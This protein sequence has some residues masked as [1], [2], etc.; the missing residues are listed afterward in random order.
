MGSSR[1]RLNAQSLRYIF[2]RI[3]SMLVSLGIV[4]CSS[5]ALD[6]T[7][8][9]ALAQSAPAQSDFTPTAA[10]AQAVPTHPLDALTAEEYV[11]TRSL[12]ADAGYVNGDSRFPLINLREPTKAEVLAWKP[13][14]AIPRS[15]DVVV[16]QG[17]QTYEAVVDLS[18]A[19]VKSWKE[20]EEAQPSLLLEEFIGVTELTIRNAEWRAAVQKRG[21]TDFTQIFCSPLTAGYYGLAEEEGRRILKVPCYDTRGTKN[22]WFGKPIEGVLTVVDLNNMQ[23]LKVIDTGVIPISPDPASYDQASVKKLR[24]ALNPTVISQPAGSNIT[25]EDSFINW[26]KWSFHL[27][28][29]RRL[30]SIISLVNYDDD[31]RSR[32]I[33]YQGALSEIFVPYMDP[34]EPWY[35]RT[36]MD[37]GEYGAG[38]L[39]TPLAPGI[40]CPTTAAMF[41]PVLADDN[42]N[43]FT[44]QN[45][46]CVFERSSGDPIWRHS[47]IL[48][49]TYEGRPQTD[50]VV[51]MMSTIG[52]YDYILDWIFTQS[53][54][55]NVMVG[56]TGIDAVKGVMSQTMSDPTAI[57]DTAYGSLIAPGITAPNHDHFFSFRLDL[58]I[59]GQANRFVKDVF[60][61]E[62]L[63]D[64][65]PRRSL[66]KTKSVTVPTDSEAKLTVSNGHPSR[67]RMVSSDVKNHV[68]NA[69][70]YQISPMGSQ[71]NLLLPDDYPSRRAAFANYNLWITPY[72]PNEIYAAGKYPN[73]SKG[74]DGLPEWTSHSR[75]LLDTDLVAWNTVGFHHTPVSEDWPI[76]S[77]TWHGFTLKPVNFF[78]RNPALDIPNSAHP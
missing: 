64:N 36:Y 39:S 21:V 15:A 23:V 37:V 3:I 57:D 65:H 77:T 62:K 20:V 29:D 72:H 22:N 11:Q 27:R 67:W 78:D 42:G 14:D 4:L 56:A 35:Y 70:S 16:K 47:E 25:F 76:M 12:L 52:N 18:A 55:I 49:Q 34:A 46:V 5:L 30:G 41:S 74:G 2:I 1:W 60:K 44:D 19:T 69:T 63:P 38:L 54:E 45:V 17:K 31:G 59:D 9:T 8:V 68:G 32:S 24:P 28:F 26:Q 58:D 48:N 66:W 53:G 61:T 71:T 33:L 10:L 73:Q 7:Q 40:D 13:G 6:F 51:R 43:P 50:L 75:L